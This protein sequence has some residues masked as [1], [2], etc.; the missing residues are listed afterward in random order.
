MQFQT[1]VLVVGSGLAGLM[2]AIEAAKRGRLVTIIDQ[3]GPQSIGGQ[4]YWSLG[5]LFMID[6][7]EQRRVGIKAVSYTHLTL[8]T[9]A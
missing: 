9:K 7:P 1:D 6:T 2:S 4:A 8:P 5:G 3:E